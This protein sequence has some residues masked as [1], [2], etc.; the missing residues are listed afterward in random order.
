[1]YNLNY[2]NALIKSNFSKLN[3]RTMNEWT[4]YDN[5]DSLLFWITDLKVRKLNT[6]WQH[7][8]YTIKE[9]HYREMKVI[10]LIFKRMQQQ[11]QTLSQWRSQNMSA[12]VFLML[13]YT[14]DWVTMCAR[15][16]F[17]L[18]GLW[19]WVLNT[20]YSKDLHLSIQLLTIGH[21]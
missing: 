7:Q 20:P 1:M 17:T 4:I 13:V 14:K 5:L 16:V 18:G 15:E 12:G 6:K 3:G 8:E 21:G 9:S 11:D 10:R 2:S 19:A